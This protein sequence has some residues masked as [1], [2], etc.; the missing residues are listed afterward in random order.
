MVGRNSPIVPGYQSN[1]VSSEPEIST[2]GNVPLRAVT[3]LTDKGCRFDCDSCVWPALVAYVELPA[4]N[5]DAKGHRG[6]CPQAP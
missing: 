1:G 3:V 2:V 5:W 6:L 4:A